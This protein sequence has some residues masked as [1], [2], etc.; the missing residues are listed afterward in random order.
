MAELEPRPSLA[1]RSDAILLAEVGRGSEAAFR[2]LF[3]RHQAMVY[4]TS[5]AVL[6]D[7]GEAADVVQEVFVRL[8]A[9][10]ARWRPEVALKAWLYRV[11][12]NRSIS[13]RRRIAT[14]F[15][16]RSGS[17]P[18]PALDRQLALHRAVVEL[19]A[20]MAKLG[21]R[22]RALLALNLD[23]GL[24]PSEMA[25]VLGLTANGTRVALHRALEQLRVL[26]RAAGIEL[27]EDDPLTAMATGPE[28][29]E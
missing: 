7:S 16:T 24:E 20:V 11:T 26:A 14:F 15:R 8:N 4:R 10:A 2:T 17:S 12:V 19:R 6:L 21:P 5:Y 25:P 3:V 9:E 13:V 29:D 18:R 22:Q 23:Q 28:G 1:E 27:P